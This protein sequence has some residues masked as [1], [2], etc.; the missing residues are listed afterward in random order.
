MRIAYNTSHVGEGTS[1]VTWAE[2]A[3]ATYIYLPLVL[4]DFASSPPGGG[5]VNGDFENG[6]T[7]WTEYS[8][9]GYPIIYSST[10][11]PIT[12]HSGIYAA[13]LGG[14]NDEIAYIQQQVTIPSITPWL[15]YWHWIDSDEN[16]GNDFGEVLING[17]LEDWYYL[18]NT[19]STGGWVTHSVNLSAY[20]GQS[21]KLQIGAETDSSNISNLYV[22]DVSL[23]ASA[24]ALGPIHGVAPNL[25]ASTTQGKI[26]IVAQGEKPQGIGEE[27]LLKPR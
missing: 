25:D 4:R 1:W 6:S 21:V 8:L 27:R 7:G 12:P 13:W 9:K 3:P 26:G 10:D 24:S 14:A 19:T 20:G 18:C 22:D 16:C 5:I 2:P 15:V 23:Q 17:N 11:L